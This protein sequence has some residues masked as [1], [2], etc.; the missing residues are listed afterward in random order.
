MLRGAFTLIELLVVIAIIAILAALLLPVLSHAKETAKGVT[1]MSNTRQLLYAWHMYAGDSKDVLALNQN[2]D[3]PGEPVTLTW[4]TG[5]LTWGSDG[6][7]T[8]LNYLSEGS[9][10][11]YSTLA[12]YYAA[13]LHIFKCPADIYLSSTQSGLGWQQ[14]VRSMSMNFFVGDGSPAGSKDWYTDRITYKKMRDFRRLGPAMTW[15]LVD[16]HPDSINDTTLIEPPD[17]TSFCDVPASY[18]NGACGIAYADGHSEIH[19]WLQFTT[20]PPVRYINYTAMDAAMGN[21]RDFA[22]FQA[23][24]GEPP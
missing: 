19:E 13:S 17:F 1:C 15:V 2:L 18:H 5:F 12:P 14:R 8:N 7:N 6:D 11:N 21:D 16:E 24:T 4:A 20:K 10:I 23:R 3:G 9:P 22:W